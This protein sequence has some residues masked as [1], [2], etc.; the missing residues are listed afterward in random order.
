MS[1]RSLG[2]DLCLAWPTAE[3]AVMGPEGAV[4]IINRRELD[5]SEEPEKLHRELVQR[6]RD[7]FANP[8]IA[9]ARGWIDEVIDPRQTREY[10]CRAIEI[11]GLK[12]VQRPP[13]KHGNI[14]L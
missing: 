6:Y 8:Y 1:S 10:L 2:A 7:R 3:I 12:R 4:E 14:P 11:V 5:S 9:A 13:R